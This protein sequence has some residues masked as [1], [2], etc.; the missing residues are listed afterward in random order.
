MSA[1]TISPDGNH[2]ISGSHDRTLRL[3]DLQRGELE[4][5]FA[6]RT[7][8]KGTS[9]VSPP[10]RNIP[11]SSL[12]DALKLWDR[13]KQHEL[14]TRYHALRLSALR[15]LHRWF[16]SL[17]RSH[18]INAVATTSNGRCA[19]AGTNDNS[20]EL[21][22]LRTNIL[23]RSLVG[24]TGDVHAVATTPDNRQALSGSADCTLALWDVATG[25][26]LQAFTDHLG[27]VVVVA[28][29]PDGRRAISGSRDRTLRL[30]DLEE[31]TCQAMIP[32]ES[33]PEALAVALDGRTVVV[34]DRVGNVHLFEIHVS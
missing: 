11:F 24:H 22:D 5:T 10:T 28:I 33:S 8:G 21:W 32:L 2:A 18:S 13:R 34:G 9:E 3:W 27:P 17:S 29:S 31:R 12:D 16:L 4:C 7:R 6:G 23:I 1:V 14:M 20:L 30:W 26:H 19:L 15:V 25:R